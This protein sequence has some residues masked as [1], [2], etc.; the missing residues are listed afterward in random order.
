[1]RESEMDRTKRIALILLLAFTFFCVV[2]LLIVG[3]YD[4]PYADD[5]SYGVRTHLTY[6]S[7]HS[8]IKT[9]ISAFVQVKDTYFSWQGTFSAIFLMALQPAV[10]SFQLYAMTPWIVVVAF[11]A[12]VCMFSVGVVHHLFGGDRSIGILTGILIFDV[13]IQLMPS[14][15]QGLYWYNSAVYYV[16]FFSL[17]LISFYLLVNSSC[18]NTI[19]LCYISVYHN[20]YTSNRINSIFYC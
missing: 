2:P 9:I 5:Y 4:V 10:F 12:G 3:N 13:C 16:L 7:S 8:V 15:V 11:F 1:M 17:S 14:P 18:F 19:Q 20:L 6:I